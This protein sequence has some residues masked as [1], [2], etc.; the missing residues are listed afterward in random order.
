MLIIYLLFLEPGGI[1]LDDVERSPFS[2]FK[3][4]DDPTEIKKHVEVFN[5]LIRRYKYLQRPFEETLKNILLFI[6]KWQP[7]EN[8]KLAKATGY[9]I[10]IQLATPN[11]LKVL[12]KDYLVKDGKT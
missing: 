10:T 6:N 3:S 5:K 4:E 8:S 12:L 1:V 9:F 2:I 7:D 11:V